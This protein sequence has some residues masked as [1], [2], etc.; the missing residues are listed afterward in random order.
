[1]V[2]LNNIDSDV[3]CIKTKDYPEKDR[4]LMRRFPTADLLRL[5]RAP[6]AVENADSAAERSLAGQLSFAQLLNAATN[7]VVFE[8]RHAPS[9]TSHPSPN[10]PACDNL[11]FRHIVAQA[12]ADDVRV[13]TSLAGVAEVEAGAELLDA[14]PPDPEPDAREPSATAR[15]GGPGVLDWSMLPLG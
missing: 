2:T 4:S 15:T 11:T 3:T 12:G 7:V 5:A 13:I 1:M 14:D 10:D 6:H 9:E 8:Q